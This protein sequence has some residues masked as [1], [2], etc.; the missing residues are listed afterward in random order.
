MAKCKVLE[1]ILK[2]Q[3]LAELREATES[4]RRHAEGEREACH[5]LGLAEDCPWLQVNERDSPCIWYWCYCLHPESRGPYVE[6]VGCIVNHCSHVHT[7]KCAFG[8]V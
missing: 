7:G 5:R 8:V 1:R 2:R 4:Q 3:R 6:Q